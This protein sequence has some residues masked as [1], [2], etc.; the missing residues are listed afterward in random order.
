VCRCAAS[1]GSDPNRGLAESAVLPTSNK[2]LRSAKGAN[3]STAELVRPSADL[4]PLIR[5]LAM[6]A[7]RQALAQDEEIAA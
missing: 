2:P 3:T 7:V 5:L 4:A 6:Q 1:A